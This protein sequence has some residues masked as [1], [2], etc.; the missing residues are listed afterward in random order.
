MSCIGDSLTLQESE[1][2]ITDSPPTDSDFVTEIYYLSETDD[3][4]ND[5]TSAVVIAVESFLDFE[6]PFCDEY[7][8]DNESSEV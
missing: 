5:T 3:V 8:A 4:Q 7:D 1:T 6:S 2:R